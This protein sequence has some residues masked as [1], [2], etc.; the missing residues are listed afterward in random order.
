MLRAANR[1]FTNEI[2]LH[3]SCVQLQKRIFFVMQLTCLTRLHHAIVIMLNRITKIQFLSAVNL[4][5]H[6]Q[7]K[8]DV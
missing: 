2:L 7:N 1:T 3:F 8:I 4:N 5:M 6:F